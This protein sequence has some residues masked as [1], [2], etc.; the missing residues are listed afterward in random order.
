MNRYRGQ[1]EAKENS[2]RDSQTPIKRN[3]CTSHIK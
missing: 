1:Q 2:R 3:A